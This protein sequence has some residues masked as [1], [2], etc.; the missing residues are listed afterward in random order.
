M[1]FWSAEG[2]RCGIQA[3]HLAM[4][5]RRL[6]IC[7]SLLQSTQGYETVVFNSRRFVVA[8]CN[9]QQDSGAGSSPWRRR[10]GWSST[11]G[12]ACTD[13]A[14]RMLQEEASAA[15]VSIHTGQYTGYNA[16]GHVIKYDNQFAVLTF[17]IHGLPLGACSQIWRP[18]HN[19][20]VADGLTA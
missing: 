8:I 11:S 17:V 5:G 4:H 1:S 6:C 15:S 14:G 3:W 10:P 19:R 18:T 20:Q 9:A 12:L 16:Q 13:A 7:P 2:G